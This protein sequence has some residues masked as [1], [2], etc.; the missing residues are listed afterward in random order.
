ME[1]SIQRGEL[2]TQSAIVR[3]LL[4]SWEMELSIQYH[5]TIINQSNDLNVMRYYIKLT[6]AMHR[7]HC[8]KMKCSSKYFYRFRRFIVGFVLV[9]LS[10]CLCISNK[11]RKRV[12]LYPVI[13]CFSVVNY[14]R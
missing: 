14:L 11:S 4:H 3:I 5:V 12:F 2:K 1:C 9:I 10:G 6:N 13:F 7:P 8:K